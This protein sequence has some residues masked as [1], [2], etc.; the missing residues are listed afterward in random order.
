MIAVPA[1]TPR[2]AAAHSIASPALKQFALA[3]WC[4]GIAW[5]SAHGSAH[6][7]GELPKPAAAASDRAKRDADK[8]YEQIRMHSDRSRKTPSGVVVPAQAPAAVSE[9]EQPSRPTVV[10]LT[11]TP[12]LP[13]T[14]TATLLSESSSAGIAV[15]APA[16]ALTAPAAPVHATDVTLKQVSL[17]AAAMPGGGANAVAS[18][19]TVPTLVLVSSVE[20]DFPRHLTRNLGQGSV[21]VNFEVLPDGSV[22]TARIDKSRHPGLNAAA[23]AAVAAWRFKPISKAT[24]GVTELRFE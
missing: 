23:L 19:S 5:F 9:V 7:Q 21:V 20:P 16:V 10:A 1:A 22:G 14:A 13:A 17:A 8:V 24:A 4:V 18:E 12:R 3:A 11:A 2:R 6:A 15:L